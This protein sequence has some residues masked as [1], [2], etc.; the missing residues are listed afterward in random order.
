[1]MATYLLCLACALYIF[2]LYTGAA[3]E[4]SAVRIKPGNYVR[5][6]PLTEKGKQLSRRKV[7][8]RRGR[9]RRN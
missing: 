3:S 6:L 8:N 1:M 5:P 4:F 2:H 9:Q 7:T